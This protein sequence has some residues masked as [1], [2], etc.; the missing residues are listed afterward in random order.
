MIARFGSIEIKGVLYG[1]Y[2]LLL[3]PLKSIIFKRLKRNAGF[4]SCDEKEILKFSKMMIEDMKIVDILGSW[5]K[6]EFF[7]NKELFKVKKIPLNQLE[8]YFNETPWSK[9]LENKRV[10]VI[11]PFNETIEEQYKLNRL[12]LFQ[13][14]DILP[15]FKSLET[16]KA[17]QTIAGQKSEFNSWFDALDYMKNEMDKKIYDIVIIGCGAYGFSLAAH[18]KRKGKQAIH[19]GGATQILFGIKGKRWEDNPKFSS[20]INEYFVKPNYKDIPTNSKSIEGGC[21]W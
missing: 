2:P 4:F 5:R 10:L 9:A 8:P 19:L 15:Q 1:R 17:V 3:R 14:K 12:N 13:N 18:A 6:E 16:I 20:I 11:H 21:Y 7:F